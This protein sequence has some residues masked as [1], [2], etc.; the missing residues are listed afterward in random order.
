M[1]D[2]AWVEF[3]Y[4]D[5]DN[6]RMQYEYP[7]N[8]QHTNVRSYYKLILSRP[9]LDFLTFHIGFVITNSS[10]SDYID[11]IESSGY[12]TFDPYYGEQTKEFWVSFKH[13]FYFDKDS[14]NY[15]EVLDQIYIDITIESYSIE[16]RQ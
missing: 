7:N 15:R 5:T 8:T 13:D 1:Q 16:G 2:L 10:Y 14:D 11:K 3:S 6:E 4:I 9:P 12:I